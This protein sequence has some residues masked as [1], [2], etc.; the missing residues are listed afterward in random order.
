MITEKK[1]GKILRQTMKGGKNTGTEK[2][3]SWKASKPDVN[4]TKKEQIS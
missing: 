3:E 2:L 4:P 1:I